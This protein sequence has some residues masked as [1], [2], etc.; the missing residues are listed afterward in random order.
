MVDLARIFFDTVFRNHGMSRVLLSD[1]GPQF[2]SDFW[3]DFFALLRTEVKLTSTYHSQSNGGLEK[4]NKT[5]IQTLLS[6]VSVRQD[7]WG[8]CVRSWLSGN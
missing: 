4:F 7:D 5:L 8:L 3:T 2:H 1:N 6:Y